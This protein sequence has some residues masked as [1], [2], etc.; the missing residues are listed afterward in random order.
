MDKLAEG[1]VP[2]V[3]TGPTNSHSSDSTSLQ[4]PHVISRLQLLLRYTIAFTGREC[5][6]LTYAMQA[7]ASPACYVVILLCSFRCCWAAQ[8]I[9]PY[10]LHKVWQFLQDLDQ[11][12]EQALACPCLDDLKEGPCGVSFIAAF[13][14]FLKSR[15]NEK[16]PSDNTVANLC[17][18]SRHTCRRHVSLMSPHH[19]V[20]QCQSISENLCCLSNVCYD[21][22]HH[23]ALDAPHV[24]NSN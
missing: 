10:Q 4:K 18:L 19:I 2:L 16:V 9:A 24:C 12:V 13:S 23:A 5:L 20:R 14:C 1:E 21:A 7:S 15:A 6:R 3:I 17:L 8:R 22:F 11:K